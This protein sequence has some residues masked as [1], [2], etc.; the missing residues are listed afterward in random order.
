[1]EAKDRKHLDNGRAL[2]NKI[3]QYDQKNEFD[4]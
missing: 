2:I 1:L 3:N 4:E